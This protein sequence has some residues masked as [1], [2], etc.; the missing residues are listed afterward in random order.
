MCRD[1]RHQR[2]SVAGH[3]RSAEGADLSTKEGRLQAIVSCAYVL[4]HVGNVARHGFATTERTWSLE[5]ESRKTKPKTATV[6]TCEKCFL[7]HESPKA[8]PHCGHVTPPK[9]KLLSAMKTVDGKLV[10]ITETP[11][12]R[13]KE[14]REARSM[15][16]LIA[17][18]KARGYK[19][20][21]FWAR[22]VYFGRPA[23]VNVMPR[24]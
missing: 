22:K 12:Q 17:F 15:A 24:Y 11:E 9:A 2:K 13:S 18:A 7:A 10:E 4:D 23:D 16:E 20:P 1:P 19:K 8:C 3:V 5:G 6:R 14:L 21:H